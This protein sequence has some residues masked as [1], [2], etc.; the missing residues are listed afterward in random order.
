MN[1]K[2][3]FTKKTII[4]LFVVLISAYFVWDVSQR[5]V[6]FFRLQGYEH[7]ITQLIKQAENE[8][9]APFTI[10]SGEKEISVINVSCLEQT[11]AE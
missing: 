1:F 4:V 9:C 8:D 10:F 5:V 6:I 7:A 2:K 11:E 3:I